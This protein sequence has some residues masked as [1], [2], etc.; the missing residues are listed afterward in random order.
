MIKH[1]ASSIRQ[2]MLTLVMRPLCAFTFIAHHTHIPL[3]LPVLD[4]LFQR[5]RGVVGASNLYIRRGGGA[6]CP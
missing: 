1:Q 3:L 2:L 4:T 6:K 5:R